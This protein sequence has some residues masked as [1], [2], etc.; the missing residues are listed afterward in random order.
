M[1][2]GNGMA[3]RVL[4]ASWLSYIALMWLN[5]C[6]DPQL[7]LGILARSGFLGPRICSGMEGHTVGAESAGLGAGWPERPC[8][9]QGR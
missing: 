7:P 8:W 3:A 4:G 2:D 5:L 9:Y 6:D 1:V